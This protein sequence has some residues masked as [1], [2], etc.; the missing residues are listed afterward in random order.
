VKP[1]DVELLW[2]RECPSWERALEMVRE[3]MAAA[4]VPESSLRV[5]ELG[6]EAEAGR[7]GFPGSPTIRVRGEDIDPPGPDARIGLTC[8]VYRR[9]D[10]RVSPLPQRDR[11]RSALAALAGDREV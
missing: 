1:P 11:I 2:W 6:D 10:G 3:E 7:L 4:G 8:R 9:P 5:H